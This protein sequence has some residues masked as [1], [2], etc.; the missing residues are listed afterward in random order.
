M[1]NERMFPMIMPEAPYKNPFNAYNGI[2][3]DWYGSAFRYRF[4]N[5]DENGK[6]YKDKKRKL[7]SGLVNPNRDK[8]YW[9]LR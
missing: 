1:Q 4:Y 9:L 8:T 7:E 2:L 5:R 3:N 6:P